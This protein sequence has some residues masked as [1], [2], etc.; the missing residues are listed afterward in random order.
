MVLLSNLSARIILQHLCKDMNYFLHFKMIKTNLQNDYK[1]RN[2]N[3]YSLK[4]QPIILWGPTTM[5]SILGLA[6]SL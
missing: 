3:A 5:I 1:D 2:Q 4:K 6:F